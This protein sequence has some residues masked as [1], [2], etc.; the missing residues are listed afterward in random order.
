MQNMENNHNKQQQ[1]TQTNKTETSH[2]DHVSPFV[3]CAIVFVNSITI[4]IDKLLLMI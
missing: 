2:I 4:Y 1:T 3:S